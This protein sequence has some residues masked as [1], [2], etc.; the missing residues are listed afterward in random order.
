MPESLTENEKIRLFREKIIKWYKE[1]G[2]RDL[3]WRNTGSGWA[4]LVA[5]FLLRKTTVAQV[6]K[7]YEAFLKKFPGPSD[8]LAASEEEIKEII[9]SLGIEHQRARQL[10]ELA[11]TLSQKYGGKIPCAEDE[12]KKLPGVGDYIAAEVLLSACNQPKPL[13][14]RNMI[15]VVQR[16][17]GIKSTKRRPHTDTELWRFAEKLVPTSPEDAKNFNFGVLDFA[18]KIC[19]AKNPKCTACLLKEVCNYYSELKNKHSIK[20]S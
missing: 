16:V 9:K 15:R 4:V 12:L 7:V 13:L 11:Q 8:L 10:R 1:E 3:P 2:D 6:L 17:F 19:T 14:D 18:R 5:S 20:F